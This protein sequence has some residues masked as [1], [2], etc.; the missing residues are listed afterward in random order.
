MEI[1]RED[2]KNNGCYPSDYKPGKH[3]EREE[4]SKIFSCFAG[5]N[6]FPVAG[7]KEWMFPLIPDEKKGHVS[8]SYDPKNMDMGYEKP[9]TIEELVNIWKNKVS[10]LSLET[11]SISPEEIHPE[12]L[13]FIPQKKSA[14]MGE[15]RI[16]FQMKKAMQNGVESLT[17]NEPFVIEKKGW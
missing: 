10:H 15:Q 5:E 2:I 4:L 16:S 7:V 17:Q 13:S 6:D 1:F 14:P 3:Y 12:T 9:I 11:I 8:P